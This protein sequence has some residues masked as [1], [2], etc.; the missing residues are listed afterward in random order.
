MFDN[1]SMLSDDGEIYI[2]TVVK[3]KDYLFPSYTVCEIDSFKY[4]VKD[5]NYNKTFAYKVVYY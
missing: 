4:D 1:Y 5:E 2:H 3:D